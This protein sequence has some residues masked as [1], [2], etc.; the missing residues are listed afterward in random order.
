MK[1]TA[2]ILSRGLF[3]AFAVFFCFVFIFSILTFV[4]HYFGWNIPFVEIYDNSGQQYAKISL[5]LIDF[6]VEFIFSFLIVIGMWIGLLFYE[7]YFYT[8]KEFFRVFIEDEVFNHK[9]LK[10]LKAFFYINLIPI[11]Y[12]L[13][14][15]VFQIIKNGHFK[16]EEDQGIAIFHLLIAFLVYLYMDLLKRGKVLQEENDLTI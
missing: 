13:G 12:A 7:V 9:S 3:Y 6:K 4:E 8:L 2:Y 10:R 14:L 11:I 16:F 1:N 15:S 5:P